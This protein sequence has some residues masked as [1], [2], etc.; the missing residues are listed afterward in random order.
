VS[1]WSA[2]AWRR[3]Q[4]VGAFTIVATTRCGPRRRDRQP[5]VLVG[6]TSEVHGAGPRGHFHGR[7]GLHAGPLT[8]GVLGRP[9]W[10]CH[11]AGLGCDHQLRFHGDRD[12]LLKTVSRRHH[13]RAGFAMDRRHRRRRYRHGPPCLSSQARSAAPGLS[14]LPPARL[15]CA[16]RPLWSQ[17]TAA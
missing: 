1:R 16:R 12:K 10:G 5:T 7:R 4:G 9:P 14:H 15:R 11:Q 8:W 3:R 2:L 6:Q 13:W 17:M